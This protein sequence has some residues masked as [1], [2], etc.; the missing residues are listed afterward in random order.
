MQFTHAVCPLPAICKQLSKGFDPHPVFDKLMM[1][2]ILA[3]EH[4]S[5][6]WQAD[7]HGGAIGQYRSIQYGKM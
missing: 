7:L 2:G 6:A 1:K 4:S 3:V 5:L